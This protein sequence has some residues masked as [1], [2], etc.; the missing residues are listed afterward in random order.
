MSD[1]AA[2]MGWGDDEP[3]FDEARSDAQID[4]LLR[5]LDPAPRRVLDLGCGDGRVLV[6]LARAG[7]ALV[8]MDRDAAALDACGARLA[9]AGAAA[10]L[11]V[12]DFDAAET[13]PAGPF[14]AIICLGNTIMTV[15]NVDDAVTLLA[16]AATR[17]APEGVVII[18]DCPADCWPEVAEGYWQSGLTEDGGG[19]LV[20]HASD[21]VFALRSGDAVDP[22]RPGLHEDDRVFRLWTDGALRLAA[23][24]AG[25]SAPE[26]LAGSHLLSMC[27]V[28]CA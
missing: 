22:D 13:W 4:G 14:D 15:A 25:L 21:A 5:R 1:A 3:P 10:E 16:R 2:P 26:R 24:A 12:A 18:D 11:V 8:G 6:P 7:H 9:G 20:W 17:I 28:D 23:R 19:Q 27:R